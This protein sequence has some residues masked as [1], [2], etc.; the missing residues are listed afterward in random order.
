MCTKFI[1][2]ALG[3][4]YRVE[5]ADGTVSGGP[6]RY[7]PI[8]Y[9]RFGKPVAAVMTG[10]FAVAIFFFGA[11]GGNMFQANQTFAQAKNVTGGDDGF[12]GS[13]AAAL[14]FGI[15]LA[16]LVGL[17]IIG[18]IKSIGRTTAKLVPAMAIGYVAAC[19]VVLGANAASVP[20]AFGEIISGVFAPD[21]V[22]GGVIGV[23][24]IGFQRAAFSNEAGV[25][26]APIAH[27][28]AQTKR[29]VTEGLVACSSS[30]TRWSSAR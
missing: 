8:A 21:G 9:G 19:L 13:D 6:F 3:V 24:I 16:A 18:G 10:I 22:A 5:H 27:S 12:L 20:G 29:P 15:V 25:G 14:I 7:L 23:L 17:V 11:V 28:A 26:L 4:K 2:C 1:E 30:S